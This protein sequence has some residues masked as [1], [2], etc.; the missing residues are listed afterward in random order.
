MNPATFPEPRTWELVVRRV[1][2]LTARMRAIELESDALQS[3]TYLPGQDIALSFRASDGT[4]IR[5][6][7]T[8]RSF[9]PNQGLLEINVVMHGDGPGMRW[10]ASAE[11]GM[12]IEGVAPRG[13]VT[14]AEADWHLFAGDATAVPAAFA[15]I[16]ALPREALA[17]ALFLVDDPEE[18]VPFKAGGQQPSLHWRFSTDMGAVEGT[19]I[20]AIDQAQLQGG[21]GHAYLAGE[22]GLVS[23]LKAALLERGWPIDRIS[24]KA[25]WN[26]GRANAGHGEPEQKVA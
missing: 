13:K 17:Q 4:K 18:C 19:L 25:Y 9:D 16:E 12:E 2:D 10:A 24:A 5:R 21:R 14:I 7:Y 1:R 11:P 6:R 22:V 23:S 15:M 3:F 20:A 26:R 8:I